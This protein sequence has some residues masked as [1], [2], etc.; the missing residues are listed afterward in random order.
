MKWSLSLVLVFVLGCKDGGIEPGHAD[1]ISKA[2]LNDKDQ[3]IERLNAS[4]AKLEKKNA[5]LKEEQEFYRKSDEEKGE[6][7]KKLR[8]TLFDQDVTQDVGLRIYL[9]TAH[10]NTKYRRENARLQKD[11]E[12]LRF[13]LEKRGV[14]YDEALQEIADPALTPLGLEQA[15]HEKT[16]KQLDAER[17]KVDALEADYQRRLALF[18][19]NEDSLRTTILKQEKE[20]QHAHP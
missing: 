11:N 3:E 1:A 17:A 13:A 14:Y 10:L 12:I 15:R 5:E 19:R 18:E 2:E 6:K 20:L 9:D 16:M 4:I 8:A 7:I